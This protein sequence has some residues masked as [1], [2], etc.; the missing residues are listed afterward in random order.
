MSAC[1]VNV[2]AHFVL[3]VVVRFPCDV[4]ALFGV[5]C[6]KMYGL[7]L[8]LCL[9]DSFNVFACGVSGIL[10]DAVW[11][12]VLFYVIVVCLCV[13]C[14]MCPWVSFVMYCVVVHGLALCVSCLFVSVPRFK[15]DSFVVDCVML[16]GL[17]L[18]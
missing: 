4:C 8:C 14:F 11:C 9:C 16:Y 17:F 18:L 2:C 6:V 13:F 5:Y 15:H 12:V 7:C 1:A 10:C 3:S